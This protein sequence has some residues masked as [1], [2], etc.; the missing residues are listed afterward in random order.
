MTENS[1]EEL[2]PNDSPVV[3]PED[4]QEIQ[5]ETDESRKSADEIESIGEK[6][7]QP[8]EQETIE[9]L[10]A[11]LAQVESDRDNYKQGLLSEKGR[12]RME[13]LVPKEE[14]PE[15]PD[16]FDT[17]LQTPIV[18]DYQSKRADILADY[19]GK[20][21]QLSDEE[22][23]I[24]IRRLKAEEQLLVNDAVAKNSYVAKKHIQTMIDENLD[25]LNYKFN[26]KQEVKESPVSADIGSTK[27]IRKIASPD[28]YS[29][30]DKKIAS[31][32]GMTLERY[33]EL[34][35]KGYF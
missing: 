35:N 3:P 4:N 33:T 16:N 23:K 28:R 15:L 6:Q 29:E 24:L 14:T 7:I 17:T 31:D 20:I 8:T 10:K 30:E 26:S 18:N 9:I 1:N 5:P 19:E 27:S 34:K 12:K 32:A 11:K 22:F 25:Y 2:K 13:E 21:Q